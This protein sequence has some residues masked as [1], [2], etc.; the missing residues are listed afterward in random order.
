MGEMTATAIEGLLK[1]PAAMPEVPAYSAGWL[2]PGGSTAP[3]LSYVDGGIDV[4]W[5]EQLEEMH[6]ESSRDHFM[7]VWTRRAI[8][9][10]AGIRREDTVLD[11]GCSTGYLLEDVARLYPDATLLGLDLVGSGLVKAH[12]HVP[13]ARLLQADACNVPLSD[14]SIDALLSA[15]LL[16]HVPDDQAA[17]G[18]IARVLRP[19]RRAAVVVPAGPGNYDYYDRFLD[20]ERRYARGELAAK[21]RE[22]GLRVRE[23]AYLGSLIYPA[24]WFVKQR[25]RRQRGHLRGDALAEQVSRDMAATDDSRVGRLTTTLERMLLNR[26]L[27]VPF[28]IR[29]L[30]VFERC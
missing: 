2:V 20:H 3:F 17:L 16:E 19:G 13:Q 27:R 14:A 11:L 7:D 10:R 12:A 29:N 28:G 24:F 5:S 8:L 4:N 15:N 18:E 1:V 21:G 23:D 25:N 22:A 30:V 6:E 26:G 9:D